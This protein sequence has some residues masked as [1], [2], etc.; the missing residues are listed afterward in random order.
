MADEPTSPTRLRLVPSTRFLLA[1]LICFG[2]AVQSAQQTNISMAI[3]SLVKRTHANVSSHTNQSFFVFEE[4]RFLWNEWDQQ[5]ILGA[6]WVGYLFTLIP[7]EKKRD[8]CFVIRRRVDI[9]LQVVG[10]Q[11]H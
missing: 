9:F 2:F 3:V 4:Q 6:Y 7:S 1:L 5:L 8:A 10:Y 11:L